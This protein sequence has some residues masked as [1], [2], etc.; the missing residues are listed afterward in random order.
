MGGIILSSGLVFIWQDYGSVRRAK[1]GL[2][3][4]TI[5]VCLLGIPLGFSMRD[6]IIEEKTRASIS[7]LVR[8]ETSTFQDTDIRRLKVDS[9]GNN[10]LVTLEVAAPEGTVSEQQINT[11]HNFLEQELERPISLDVSIFPVQEY[12]IPEG[13]DN[14]SPLGQPVR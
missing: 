14:R 11:V 13:I 8:F 7:R 6:L 9:R 12:S 2:T 1:K 10:L 5:V 3:V 4:S